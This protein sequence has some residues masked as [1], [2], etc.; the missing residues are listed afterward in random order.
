M[1][2]YT[3]PEFQSPMPVFPGWER[4]TCWSVI[5]IPSALPWFMVHLRQV[6]EKDTSQVSYLIST[7]AQMLYLLETMPQGDKVLGLH[8]L[9]PAGFIKSRSWVM[10]TISKIWKAMT[11]MGGEPF[12]V[13]LF[14][15]E[16]G[17]LVVDPP[18]EAEP[19]QVLK[20]ELLFDMNQLIPDISAR[21]RRGR[22]TS[23]T[24][25]K[26]PPA[27]RRS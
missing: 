25:R 9:I 12:E 5:E 4:Y 10:K 23:G 17:E 2:F 8:M 6:V 21:S 19:D 7:T 3:L 16:D 13:T 14:E 26:S 15:M 11:P 22:A 24:R 18:V 20:G 1:N 27:R